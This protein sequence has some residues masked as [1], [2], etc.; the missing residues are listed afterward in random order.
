MQCGYIHDLLTLNWVDMKKAEGSHR[1]T[2]ES[3]DDEPKDTPQLTGYPLFQYLT[4]PPDLYFILN[5][6]FK[7]RKNNHHY[8]KPP[9]HH[10]VVPHAI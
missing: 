6:L 8:K 2:A 10:P 4:V 3:S 5:Q 1:V 7:E 9:R